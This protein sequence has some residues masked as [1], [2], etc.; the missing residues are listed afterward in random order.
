MGI[1]VTAGLVRRPSAA[2]PAKRAG[3]VF[4]PAAEP[5]PAASTGGVQATTVA[6]PPRLKRALKIRAVKQGTTITAL[7]TAA[8]TAAA[9]D[10]PALVAVAAELASPPA[11]TPRSGL[12]LPVELHRRLKIAAV[13]HDTTISALIVAALTKTHPELSK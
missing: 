1:D 11:G 4:Q 5:P 3:E 12:Y 9:A 6:Y 8:A 7:V 2:T 13:E 10:I